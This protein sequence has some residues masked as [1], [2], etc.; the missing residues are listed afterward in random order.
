M[1][2]LDVAQEY[3]DAWNRRDP[4]GIVA[5]FSEGGTYNDPVSNG[6]LSGQALVEYTSGLLSSF[7]NEGDQHWVL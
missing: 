7:P 6:D 2:G 3:F 1:S 5:T 4:A